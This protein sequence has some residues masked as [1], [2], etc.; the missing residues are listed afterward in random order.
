LVVVA[1]LMAGAS[2]GVYSATEHPLEPPDRSS[3]RATLTT[4]LDSI[5]AAWKPYSTGD[6]G[7]DIPFRDARECLDLSEIPPLVVQ[8]VSSETA[9]VLKEVLDRI[10]LP[11]SNETPDRATVEELGLTRWTVPRTEIHLVRIAEGDRRG[12]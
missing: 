3:P 5:D 4:F 6:P 7:F 12:Q 11:P 10:E 8:D 1:A 2:S 9:L